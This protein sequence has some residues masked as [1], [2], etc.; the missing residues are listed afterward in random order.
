MAEVTNVTIQ[1]DDC[2]SCEQCVT[3]C[4]AVFEMADD[5]AVVKPEAK[6]PAFCKSNSDGIVAAAESCPSEAIKYETA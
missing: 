2:I 4:D 6:N 3:E 1:A 5:K